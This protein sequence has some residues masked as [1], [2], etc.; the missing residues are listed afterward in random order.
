MPHRVIL[1][2]QEH[3][4]CR[5]PAEYRESHAAKI[6][7]RAARGER[8]SVHV[9]PA[10][11]EARIDFGSWL[12]D[13]PCGAGNATTPAWGFALCYGCGAIHEGVVFPDDWAAIEAT[14]LARPEQW[15]RAWKSDE[16]VE[17]LRTENRMIGVPA[18]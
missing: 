12:V 4:L 9:D 15:Q 16:T 8:I 2:P 11:L 13:C 10:P 18:T 1:G 7:K 6:A 3:H 14:I 17:D 5:T